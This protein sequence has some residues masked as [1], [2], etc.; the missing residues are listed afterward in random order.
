[1]LYLRRWKPLKTAAEANPIAVIVRRRNPFVSEIV[2]EMSMADT[3]A[4]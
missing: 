1:M 4:P 3:L 2:S